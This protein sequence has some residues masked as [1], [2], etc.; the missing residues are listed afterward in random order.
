MKATIIR[1]IEGKIVTTVYDVPSLVPAMKELGLKVVDIVNEPY[2]E[3]YLLGLPRF[4]GL[5]KIQLGTAPTCATKISTPTR[6]SSMR[7]AEPSDELRYHRCH[8]RRQ[9]PTGGSVGGSIH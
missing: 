2:M 1:T 6:Y 9:N 7:S 4:E 8:T 5:N 3:K